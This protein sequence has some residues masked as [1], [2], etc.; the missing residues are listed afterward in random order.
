MAVHGNRFES[1]LEA[2]SRRSAVLAVFTSTLEKEASHR[3]RMQ[4]R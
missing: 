2:L 4:T 1:E 3:A